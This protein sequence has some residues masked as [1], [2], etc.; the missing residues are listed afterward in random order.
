MLHGRDNHKYKQFIQN[1]FAVCPRQALHARTLGFIHPRSGQE[2]YFTSEL[3][4]DMT[5][6]LERWRSYTAHRDME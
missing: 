6:L 3:P 1:C 4:A 5:A 2:M